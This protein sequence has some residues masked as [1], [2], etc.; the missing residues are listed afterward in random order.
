MPGQ[1]AVV[2]QLQP[3]DVWRSAA[4]PVARLPANW[5]LGAPGPAAA[6][7]EVRPQPFDFGLSSLSRQLTTLAR[8]NLRSDRPNY[9][10]S[11]EKLADVAFGELFRGP[12]TVTRWAIVGPRPLREVE[13]SRRSLFRWLSRVLQRNTSKPDRRGDHRGKPSPAAALVR[14]GNR[15]PG[16]HRD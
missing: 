15:R 12:R 13:F 6:G 3:R 14:G 16:A 2:W 7:P 4:S 9:L 1:L 11:V 8:G 5:E 10:D